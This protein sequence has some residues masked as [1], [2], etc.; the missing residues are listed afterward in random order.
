MDI[1]KIIFLFLFV[2]LS[3]KLILGQDS[4]ANINP[5]GVV[6]K[7][8]LFGFQIEAIS[9][10]VSSELGALIDYDIYSSPNKK[11]NY[12]LRLSTE[13]FD[14]TNFD[15]GG[16]SAPGPFF[17]FNIY[18]CHS[19]RGKNFWFS[20][21]IGLAIHKSLENKS[22]EDRESDIQ[23]LLKW[24]LELKYNLYSNN[25]GLLLKF[26]VPFNKGTGYIG[27]GISI[28]TYNRVPAK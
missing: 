14:M 4:T 28:G 17:D 3:P 10:L 12:G 23:G 19:I 26:A 27:F 18:A 8:S 15:I 24:G 21:L 11:Y 6:F 13:Y 1:R 22:L 2:L 20:P 7:P 25:V 5:N 16:K 9:L